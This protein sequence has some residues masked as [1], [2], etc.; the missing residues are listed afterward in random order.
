[1]TVIDERHTGLRPP[2]KAAGFPLPGRPALAPYH[3]RPAARL[4]A[5]RARGT[6]RE[7]GGEVLGIEDGVRKEYGSRDLRN[8]GFCGTEQRVGRQSP[9]AALRRRSSKVRSGRAKRRESQR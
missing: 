6:Q 5:R 8:R 4:S 1:M 7:A 2:T 3:E 9:S